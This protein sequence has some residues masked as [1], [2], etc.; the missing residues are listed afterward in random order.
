VAEAGLPFRMVTLMRIGP[1]A[2]LRILAAF[3]A[4]LCAS[5]VLFGA[6]TL[7]VNDGQPHGDPPYL[8]EDGW[9]PLL[10]GGGLDGWTF[11][12]PE[13]SVWT[14]AAGLYWD[15]ISRPNELLTRPGNGTRIVNGPKGGI[16]NIVTAEKFGD[17]ELY[18][19]FLIPAKSN[20]GVYLEG[21]YEVQVFDSFGVEHPKSSDC[22]GI[23]ERWINEKG[24]GGTPPRVNASRRPGE[25][26][27]YQVWFQTPRFDASGKK[28][29]NA[30]FLRV[31]QNGIL[32][33]ENV[34]VD[35]PTRSGLDIPEAAK[36]PLMLQGDHGPVAYRN[37]YIRGLRPIKSP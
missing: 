27:S 21:L 12:H 5:V 24:V 20:S 32:I 19:E 11:E 16:S 9:T 14:T 8:L 6:V 28:T 7:V 22:G 33:H 2:F 30:K 10:K 4:V 15:G 17:V 35:G 36:N 25:W 3:V 1:K 26:Q 34:E 23:Y 31:L 13:K 37:I 18:L 29:A